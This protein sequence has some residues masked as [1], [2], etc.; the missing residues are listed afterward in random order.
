MQLP[1]KSWLVL[2][3]TVTACGSAMA[4]T[5]QS[6]GNVNTIATNVIYPQPE[7]VQNVADFDWLNKPQAASPTH[8]EQEAVV[9]NGGVSRAGA[10]GQIGTLKA[11]AEASYPA[12]TPSNPVIGYATGTAQVS[13]YDTVAVTGAGLAIGT[14]VTYTLSIYVNGTQSRPSSEM[15]G[16]YS[17]TALVEARLRDVA[18]GSSTIKYWNAD[19]DAVGWY[20]LA[21]DTAVGNELGV[22]AMLYVGAYVSA[23]A[24]VAHSAFADYGHSAYYYLTPSIA[25][26]N[27]VGSSG[28]DFTISAAVPEPQAWALAAIGFFVVVVMTSKKPASAHRAQA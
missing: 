6:M 8:I 10:T 1:I 14:P 25:G 11:W 7:S 23:Y 12:N 27:T 4:G 16:V 21:L 15:G 26:L 5:Y 20:T 18:Q 24:T 3:L 9:S 13:F 17:A 22:S 2:S 28:H 19:K